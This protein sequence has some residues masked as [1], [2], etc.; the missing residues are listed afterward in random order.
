MVLKPYLC[1][2]GIWTI[3]VGCTFY[4]NGA[5][6]KKDDPPI[7]KERAISLFKNLL[8]KFEAVVNKNVKKT[9]SQNQFDALVSFVFNVGNGAFIKSTLL[10]RVNANPSDPAI[11]LEFAKWRNVNGKPHKGLEARRKREYQLY[12]T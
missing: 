9:L 3:G 6:V 7:S 10:K 12:T 1:P 2:A 4:E 8:S 5:P 11:G